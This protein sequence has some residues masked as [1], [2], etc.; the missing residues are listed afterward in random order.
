MKKT[1]IDETGSIEQPIV[2]PESTSYMVYVPAGTY[3]TY[4]G[5]KGKVVAT[6]GRPCFDCMFTNTPMCKKMCCHVSERP[7]DELVYFKRL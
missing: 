1:I 6:S 2:I 4:R 3:I 7:D 5:Q